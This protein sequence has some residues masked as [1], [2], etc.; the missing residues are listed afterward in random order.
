MKKQFQRFRLRSLS[1]VVALA[2]VA[3][4]AWAVDPFSVRDIRLE[5]LQRVEPGTVFASLPFRIGEQYTDD[6]GSAAIRALFALGL[7]K[8][9][10]LETAGDVLVVIVEE[11]PT[12]A[13]VDFVGSREFDKDAL[14][15]ALREIGLTEGRPYDQSLAD[16]AEQE[17]KRQYINKSL[18]GSEVVTTVT[19]I[20]RNRVNLTFTVTEGEPAKIKE[21][22]IV[23]NKAFPEATLKGLFDLDSGGILSF[24][25]KSDRYARTKL[26]ADLETLRSYY[27]SRGFLEFRIE[28]TPVAISPN[29]QD[30][31]ITVNVSEGERFV[32]SGIK[33]EGNY[34]GKE[35]EFK[36]LVKIRPGEPYNA[37]Q[38]AETTKAFTDYFGRFGF[39]FAQVE[40][41]PEIDR[42]N[43]RVAFVLVA[44]PSRRAYVRRINVGGN[45]RTRDEVIRREFR[46]FESSWY[47]GDRIKL[48]RDRLDRLG[49]FKD[50]NVETSDVPGASDQVDLNVTV[51]EKPTG[52]LQLGAGFSSAEKLALSFSIKQENAFGSGNYLGVDVNTS[53]YNRTIAFTTVNPYFTPDGISRTIDVYHRS[54]KPYENQGGNYSLSTSGAGLRFGV[55][56]SEFDTVFF[57]ITGERT[58]IQ[59]G[60]NIPAA[61]LA[62]A[63]RFG[64]TSYAV[65]LSIGWSRDDR[66]SALAPTSGRYQRLGTEW[67]VAADARYVRANYQFQQYVALSKRFTLALNGEAGY[68]KGLSGRPYPVFKNFYSGGLGSV[69]GFE[70]GTLGP[71]D[72][73]GSVIGGPKKVTLNA[74]VITPFPGAGNDKTLRLFGFVDAGNVYGENEK[75]SLST[76]RSSTGFGVSW[77]SPIG[78]LRL[79]VA[80]PLRKFAGDRIQKLQFQIGTSF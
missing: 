67:G 41:R 38:V 22:H 40:A 56:F 14:K 60:T 45:N 35:Q 37:D 52:S 77:I 21:I 19:P 72:V 34:L 15:K 5:G 39:A 48:S 64:N 25:T 71:R 62:Y 63:A 59:P 11:R 50:V 73:T 27:L 76:L 23:G 75:F 8:D 68:G 42:V 43:N 31:S 32:V 65:P 9:V 66:D 26:N 36:S 7:F 61:Y 13:D 79:A 18:Y 69:R 4:T 6:K 46:Q 57:G 47:D 51:T 53:K 2:F 24:Y 16:R 30:I 74:E 17:L 49:F 54:S 10:R 78:P 28:S 80:K 33:L 44:D 58:T 55:P 29:K 70:Q 20:E 1:A 12:V 3:N